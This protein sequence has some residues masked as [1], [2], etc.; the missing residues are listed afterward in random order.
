[1]LVLAPSPKHFLL[2]KAY[3]GEAKPDQPLGPYGPFTIVSVAFGRL[4]SL[5]P[6]PLVKSIVTVSFLS[7]T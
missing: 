1:V 7:F 4:G 5:Y 6:V 3:V 2:R